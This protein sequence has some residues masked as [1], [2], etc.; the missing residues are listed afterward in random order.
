MGYATFLSVTLLAPQEI[1]PTLTPPSEAQLRGTSSPL[2]RYTQVAKIQTL[3]K[4]KEKLKNLNQ[5]S[6]KI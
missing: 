4:K 2:V 6:Q 5:K 3:P 1:A